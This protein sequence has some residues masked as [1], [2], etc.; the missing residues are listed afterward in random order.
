M[1]KRWHIVRGVWKSCV[2]FWLA[3]LSTLSSSPSLIQMH[4]N[5]QW[6]CIKLPA[7][8]FVRHIGGLSPVP[9]TG[10]LSCR[11]LTLLNLTTIRPILRSKLCLRYIFTTIIRIDCG[12]AVVRA[13][14]SGPFHPLFPALSSRCYWKKWRQ[15]LKKES[16]MLWCFYTSIPTKSFRFV[17]AVSITYHASWIMWFIRR[18]S[19]NASTMQPLL[20]NAEG[21][22]DNL[23]V[24]Y[25][26]AIVY[27][28]L[29]FKA[30]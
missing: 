28:R 1:A 15:N 18:C 4:P 7:G 27:V 11:S 25:R 16:V 5:C 17:A 19:L 20:P 12:I 14:Y 29:K 26:L 3:K 8:K 6:I 13:K 22:C 30:C 9:T 21:L 2:G 24:G 23:F 10:G